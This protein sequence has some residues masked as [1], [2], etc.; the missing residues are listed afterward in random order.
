MCDFIKIVAAISV[1]IIIL[2]SGVC[3]HVLIAIIITSWPCY[4]RITSIIIA[5]GILV[6]S[7]LF[8]LSTRLQCFDYNG[9]SGVK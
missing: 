6:V 1:I 8:R 2:A 9:Y 4:L 7:I 3:V 5:Y